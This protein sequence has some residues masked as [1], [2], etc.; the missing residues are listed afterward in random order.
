MVSESY[1]RVVDLLHGQGSRHKTISD[2]R[3]MFQ[4]PAHDDNNPSLEV[5]DKGGKTILACYANCQTDDVLTALGLSMSDLFDGELTPQARSSHMGTLV[6]SY[7]YEKINGDPW[8]WV[9][10][11]FPKDFRQRLPG[12]EPVRDLADREAIRR[13]GFGKGGRP[14]IV[15]HA[16]KVWRAMQKGGAVVWW[17]DGEK[18]VER[19]E[20]DGLVAT[21]APGFAKWDQKYAEFLKGAA[22]IVMV[23]DQDKEKPDGN[24]GAGQQAAIAARLGFRA[25]GLKVRVV[26]P[27]AGKDYSDHRDAGH[28]V[29]DFLT[30]V[31][32][33]ARPRGLN[34]VDLA[35]KVFDPVTWAVEGLLTTGL[36]IFAGSPKVGKSWCC[37]DI[38][39]AVAMGGLALGAQRVDQGNVLYLAREDTFRRLQSRLAYVMGGDLDAI[40]KDL[41]MVPSE[42]DWPGG[43]EGLANLTEWA[44]EVRK[45][46]LVVIDTIARLEPAMGE[47]ERRGAYAGQYEMMARYKNW[48]DQN[49]VAVLVVHHDNKTKQ[50][51][52]HEGWMKDPFTAIS[53][54]RAF[55]GAADTMLFL[56]SKRFSPDGRLH[57]TGRD[58]EEQ[59][60]GMTKRGALWT[61]FDPVQSI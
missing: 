46:R 53:G 24:L 47:T 59:S 36:T 19:A 4:C 56:E 38:A 31:I 8:Y 54:T 34:G 20:K 23:V 60:L 22:E 16:P 43:E 37:L 40:P 35:A 41:E 13:L 21:C 33:S 50:E 49:N 45:P 52:D 48:G 17:L 51:L 58:V 14:P 26:K 39:A 44:E 11:Y 1:E 32:V 29:D 18:D 7:L 2:S 42:V 6:R 57:V 61:L 3:I 30:D 9:D 12:V 5:I 10:R 27:A 28:G 55:T 15:Y 25:V